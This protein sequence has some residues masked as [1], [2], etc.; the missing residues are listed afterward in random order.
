MRALVL[1]QRDLQNLTSAIPYQL[2]ILRRD[3]QAGVLSSKSLKLYVHSPPAPPQGF[4]EHLSSNP[5]L[6]HLNS[7]DALVI[8]QNP[9]TYT[10]AYPKS[11]GEATLLPHAVRQGAPLTFKASGHISLS[12]SGSSVGRRDGRE[13]TPSIFPSFSCGSAPTNQA[14]HHPLP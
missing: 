9:D 1:H 4:P 6:R 10:V 3:Q 2:Y 5:F 8:N 13:R 11:P 7:Q 12:G 14:G